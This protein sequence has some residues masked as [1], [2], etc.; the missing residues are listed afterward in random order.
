MQA[1]KRHS[2]LRPDGGSLKMSPSSREGR[3][4]GQLSEGEG[5]ETAA[6]LDVLKRL[7]YWQRRLPERGKE[8]LTGF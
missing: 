7:S 3:P 6:R 2:E 1:A 4:V 8:L 5:Q